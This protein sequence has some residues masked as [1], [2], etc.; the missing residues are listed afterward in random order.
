LKKN[1][2]IFWNLRNTYYFYISNNNNNNQNTAIMTTLKPKKIVNANLY[3]YYYPTEILQ[4]RL[5]YFLNYLNSF[6][7]D[8][9]DSRKKEITITVRELLYELSDRKNKEQKTG[10]TW[11]MI[12]EQD[13]DEMRE[14]LKK[15]YNPALR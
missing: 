7:A 6:D 15:Q 3:Q 1:L 14:I 5:V 4:S 2:E 11:E 9:S 8:L 12:Y 10:K 13:A